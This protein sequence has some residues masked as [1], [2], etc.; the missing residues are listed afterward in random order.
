MTP[1][2]WFRKR[3]AAFRRRKERHRAENE[4][5]A[6]PDRL[7]LL[8]DVLREEF[9]AISNKPLQVLG[10]GD[11][12]DVYQAIHA[13]AYNGASYNAIDLRP[14]ALCLSG[15]G[16]RS[17]SFALGVIQGL[18]KFDCLGKFHYLSTV[19]G[20]GYV[21]GLLSSWISRARAE[22]QDFASVINE[23]KRPAGKAEPPPLHRLRAST[24]FLTPEVGLAS[25]DTWAAALLFLRN[26]ILNWLILIPVGL[27]IMLIPW[28]VA[29][30]D[31]IAP[32]EV[33]IKLGGIVA[34]HLPGAASTR[35]SD[36][37]AMS[38]TL[39]ASLVFFFIA[40]LTTQITA[41]VVI[42]AIG[43]SRPSFLRSSFLMFWPHIF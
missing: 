11:L 37:P 7:R 34:S 8:E 42:A 13:L 12:A 32:K 10:R 27:A 15:G 35:L 38:G 16:I 33:L 26:V 39:A 23:L 3:V 17:S 20:G 21:G 30:L 4:A 18:A 40:T 22:G 14:T 43:R 19:S 36:L 5:R 29:D 28:A 2:P 24:N 31:G 6:A 1:W 41:P 9:L 25:A